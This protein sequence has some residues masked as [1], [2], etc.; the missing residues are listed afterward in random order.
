MAPDSSH[1]HRHSHGHAPAAPDVSS[2]TMGAAV[3]LTL[4]FVVAE[5]VS[6]WFAH[7]LALLSDAGHNLATRRLL[8]SVGTP[9]G[10]PA[11]RRT[12]E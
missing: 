1:P 6:G 7:S 2:R 3:V 12:R 5:A 10:S 4:L 8:D 9:S 11:S